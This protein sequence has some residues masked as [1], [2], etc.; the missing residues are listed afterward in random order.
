MYAHMFVPIEAADNAIKPVRGAI[1]R[2]PAV[3][4]RPENVQRGGGQTTTQQPG[5]PA[6]R[7]YVLTSSYK[8]TNLEPNIIYIFKFIVLKISYPILDWFF[9]RLR[10]SHYVVRE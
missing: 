8:K 2:R 3:P 5:H 4:V 6:T 1:A 10:L 9:M 7:T